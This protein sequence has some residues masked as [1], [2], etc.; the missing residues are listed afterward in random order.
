MTL[1]KFIKA[2]FNPKYHFAKLHFTIWGPP[3]PSNK[4]IQSSFWLPC[5]GLWLAAELPYCSS[6]PCQGNQDTVTLHMDQHAGVAA[7]VVR[8]HL[9][10]WRIRCL[11]PQEEKNHERPLQDRKDSFIQE[12]EEQQPLRHA[13]WA[14]G[15]QG[16][17]N[18]VHRAGRSFRLPLCTLPRPAKEMHACVGDTQGHT[19]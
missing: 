1:V 6:K 14:H 15:Q 16:M 19:G 18:V 13:M 17:R 4:H 3:F 7:V 11:W 10:T 12:R 2:P 8:G 5:H 9:L